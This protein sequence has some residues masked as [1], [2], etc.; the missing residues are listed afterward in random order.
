MASRF[1]NDYSRFDDIADSD[2]DEEAAKTTN[3]RTNTSSNDGT[4]FDMTRNFK[5]PPGVEPSELLT[6]QEQVST[7]ATN[8]E[9]QSKESTNTPSPT[10]A[11]AVPC[12]GPFATAE[13]QQALASEG[14]SPSLQPLNQTKKGSEAGRYVFEHQGRKVYEWDQNLDGTLRAHLFPGAFAYLPK[15]R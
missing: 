6:Q 14:L 9:Q 11:T 15:L 8:E 13:A 1:S 7:P 2:S 3:Q 12:P 5:T 10:T 4:Y